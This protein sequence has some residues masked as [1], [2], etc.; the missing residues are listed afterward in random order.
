MSFAAVSGIHFLAFRFQL[1]YFRK[2]RPFGSFRVSL[3]GMAKKSP[4]VEDLSDVH[5]ADLFLLG[6][7][8]EDASDVH[9]AAG[10]DGSDDGGAGRGDIFALGASHIE[11]KIREFN[12]EGPAEAAAV[13]H[14]REFDVLQVPDIFQ[15]FDGL[16]GD[17]EFTPAVASDVEGDFLRKACAQLGDAEDIHEKFGEFHDTFSDAGDLRV[18]GEE[19]LK[20]HA[21]HGRT[22]AGRTDDPVVVRERFCEDSHDFPC[23][24]PRAGVER[25][26]TAAGLTGR[27]IDPHTEPVQDLHHRDRGMR[28]KLVDI[29]R[30]EDRRFV[31]RT[32]LRVLPDGGS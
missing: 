16:V 4:A 26:L 3:K 32:V 25:R 12:A 5:G 29:A 31:R 24:I 22:G 13:F 11:G 9:E 17:P 14:M 23:L 2:I 6:I 21:A 28:V 18:I 10:V 15:Q 1:L 19:V 27:E 8:L 20:K 7:E 30:D